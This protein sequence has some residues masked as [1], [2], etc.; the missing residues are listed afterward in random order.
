MTSATPVKSI[1]RG[2]YAGIPGPA[3]RP[4]TGEGLEIEHRDGGRPLSTSPG[5]PPPGMGLFPQ[6]A[7]GPQRI[8]IGPGHQAVPTSMSRTS[9]QG[10]AML[11][12]A[13]SSFMG[14]YNAAGPPPSPLPCPP[15]SRRAPAPPAKKRMRTVS[16][17]RPEFVESAQSARLRSRPN[18]LHRPHVRIRSQH[19]RTVS[20]PRR[21]PTPLARLM[22]A[23]RDAV[24]PMAIERFR[25]FVEVAAKDFA[26]DKNRH[27]QSYQPSHRRPSQ[28]VCRRATLTIRP[29]TCG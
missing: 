22:L 12:D 17:H 3:C 16:P 26:L 20:A 27:R 11:V 7:L 14:K 6:A 29:R 21:V 23:R 10:E 4:A 18:D 19:R 28:D 13:L 5:R 25:L 15:P 2:R 1:L 9:G 24:A 8:G